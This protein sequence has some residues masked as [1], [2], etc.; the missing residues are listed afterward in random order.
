MVSWFVGLD[1]N[2]FTTTD[3]KFPRLKI[4]GCDR[5]HMYTKQYNSGVA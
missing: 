1:S 4:A 5:V 2:N 3:H